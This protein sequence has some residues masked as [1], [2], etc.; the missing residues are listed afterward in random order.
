MLKEKILQYLDFKGVSKYECYQKTGITNG[1]FSKKEGLSEDNILRF[2]SYYVDINLDWLL[3]GRGEM[4]RQPAVELEQPK[5]S[6]DGY[7]E[8]YFEVLEKYTAAL[9]EMKDFQKKLAGNPEHA[10]TVAAA[11]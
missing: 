7:R 8:K 2:L 5:P 3:M 4:L 9:E 6:D 10:A 11:G 1:I